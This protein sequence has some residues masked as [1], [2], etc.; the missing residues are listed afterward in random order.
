MLVYVAWERGV[1]LMDGGL[2]QGCASSPADALHQDALR[3]AAEELRSATNT[4]ATSA[5]K[6]KQQN[7]SLLMLAKKS[8]KRV[9]H[10]LARYNAAGELLGIIT[11]V[12]TGGAQD[13]LVVA[14][15]DDREV[16]VP[17]VAAIVPAVDLATGRI[18]MDPPPGLFD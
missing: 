16:E 10:K 6:R 14:T 18:E 5:M 15:P 8:S 7:V 9:E 3:S 12:I 4:A 2:T 17:F 1:Q 11:A 13:R